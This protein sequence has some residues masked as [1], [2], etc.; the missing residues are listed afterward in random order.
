M[1]FEIPGNVRATA[2]ERISQTHRGLVGLRAEIE[3]WIGLREKSDVQK[4]YVTQLKT[5]KAQLLYQL[6]ELEP[7]CGA[8]SPIDGLR[9]VYARCRILDRRL[10][11]IRRL[12]TYFQSK[13]D[14]R[15]DDK[16][17][18]VLKAADDVVWSCYAQPFRISR[19]ELP[20]HPLPYVAPIYSPY[21]I[22]R[23]EPP[24][25]LR[26]DVDA[27]FL[28]KML[29][30]IPISIVGIPTQAIEEPWRLAFLAHEVGHH[31]Q[32]DFQKGALIN[33]FGKTLLDAGG[34]RW[35]DWNKE[36]FADIFSLMMIGPWAL[37]A[38]A[39]L[40]WTDNASML[41]D[42][43]PRYPCALVRLMFMAT[44][45][46]KLDLQGSA[47]LRG[48]QSADLLDHGPV[49]IKKRDVRDSVREDLDL[50]D[51]VA[52]AAADVEVAPSLKLSD[53][54][55]FVAA[56]FQMPDGTAHLW[57]EV[58][59]GRKAMVPEESLRSSRLVLSGGVE[60]WAEICQ[61]S[62]SETRKKRRDSLK[63]LLPSQIVA[64]REAITRAVVPLAEPEINSRNKQLA[65]LLL[66]DDVPGLESLT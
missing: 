47:A 50:L 64:N 5:L 35:L 42:S 34:Q 29:H 58:L 55:E 27:E 7:Q 25:D 48:L 13:F 65:T 11:W 26:S 20:P 38:L 45:A 12:W 4:Q 1:S 40:I 6:A 15:Y 10:L 22:P 46:D 32:F 23:D 63:D 9:T 66:G 37:W 53:L 41:D 8:V 16:F 57:G 43:N 30:N 51:Q 3:T 60:A 33:S 31:V 36:L 44:V 39:E 49:L 24:Q 21:A 62:D 56:D 18:S 28:A 2:E 19:E 61:V 59:A 14:Q 17:K 54:C 52:T